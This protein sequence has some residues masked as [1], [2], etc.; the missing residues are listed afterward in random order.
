V[1]RASDQRGVRLTGECGPAPDDCTTR[2]LSRHRRGG[3]E[4]DPAIVGYPDLA[5]GGSDLS[6]GAADEGHQSPCFQR[7]C[8][9]GRKTEQPTRSSSWTRRKSTVTPLFGRRASQAGP[10]RL[11]PGSHSLRDGKVG[12][13]HIPSARWISGDHGR[14]AERVSCQRSSP[15]TLIEEAYP[16]PPVCG[17]SL[18]LRKVLT[19]LLQH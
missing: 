14:A 7:C 2:R 11:E 19:I 5:S 12:P 18:V 16:S 1:K 3:T 13:R 8:A 4:H 9:S 17:S 10:M 6:R 15:K